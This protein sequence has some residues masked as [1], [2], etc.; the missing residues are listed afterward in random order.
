MGKRRWKFYQECVICANGEKR[1]LQ[2]LK[3]LTRNKIAEITGIPV[4]SVPMFDKMFRPKSARGRFYK[5]PPKDPVKQA[6][7]RE[8]KLTTK[9]GYEHYYPYR[10]VEK[11]LRES[12]YDVIVFIPSKEEDESRITCGNAI[13]SHRGDA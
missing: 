4:P 6:A 5:K 7:C 2:S 9:D 12:G 3:G 8:K 1:S 13:L 11:N 10:D